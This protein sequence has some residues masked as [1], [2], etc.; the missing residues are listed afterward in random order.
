M[1]S[2]TA[3]A[4]TFLLLVSTT[5]AGG[6]A[7]AT[8]TSHAPFLLRGAPIPVTAAATWPVMSGDTIST[9]KSPATLTLRDGGRITMGPA[10]KARL[11]KKGDKLAFRLLAGT[12]KFELPENSPV[13]LYRGESATTPEPM[14]EPVP[15]PQTTAGAGGGG[16]MPTA[17]KILIGALVVGGGIGIG[18][19]IGNTGEDRPAPPPPVGG[20]PLSPAR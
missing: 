10:S 2:V 12:S 18:Y 7:V 16:G 13:A 19:A 4:T 1:K 5:F 20:P 17:M 11:E 9:Q 8:V 3:L 14:P 6:P 15:A